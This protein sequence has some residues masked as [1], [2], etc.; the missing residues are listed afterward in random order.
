MHILGIADVAVDTHGFAVLC[1]VG[2]ALELVEKLL[3]LQKLRA[4]CHQAVTGGLVGVDDHIAGAAVH[5]DLTPFIL[6][7]EL[8]AHA[9]DGGDAHGAGQDRGVAGAGTAGGDKAQDLGLVELYGLAGSQIVSGEDHGH[10]GVDAALY[11]AGEY[12][13]DAGGN[14]LHVS[15]AGLHVAVVHGGEHRGKL[16]GHIGDHSLGVLVGVLDQLLNGLFIVQVLR[17]ELVGL[18][19]HGG[20]VAGL[21]AGLLRQNAELLD[22]LG[23]GCLE[24]PTR[25][26][27]RQ[28]HSGGWWSLRAD[29]SRG[30]LRP[31]RW[32]RPCPE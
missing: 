28:S 31:H 11:D 26:R 25:R 10:I 9:D 3:A 23:L 21:L 7:L 27:C 8:V 13:D 30:G 2:Q 29:R 19:E 18:K 4:L 22:G 5:N 17:H 24:A 15:G 1:L 32:K 16:R 12:A 20:L 14:V 6:G